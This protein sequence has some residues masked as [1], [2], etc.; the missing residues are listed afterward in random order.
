MSQLS[1]DDARHYMVEQQIR[2]WDVLDKQVL[3]LLYAVKRE[4]F[5]LP[6][7][8]NLAFV[9]APLPTLEGQYMLEPKMEARLLQ[10]L[11]LSGQEQIA[12][13]GAGSGYL[14]ALIAKLA[15]QVDAFEIREALA[16]WAQ[17]QLQRHHIHNACIHHA[18][19]LAFLMETPQ[20][21]DAILLTGSVPS[22][23]YPLLSA[24]KPNGFLLAMVGEK[25][26]MSV[27]RIHADG[28]SQALFDTCQESLELP[29]VLYAKSFV[30]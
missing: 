19:G 10:E 30:L 29:S 17:D 25:P 6:Q 11:R 24:L 2:P 20:R 1:L 26:S 16:N 12:L 23:P 4:E 18:D 5:V 7:Y 8:Q 21:Y 9:D 27:V 3:N 22:I 28:T 13:V 14:S 15:Q